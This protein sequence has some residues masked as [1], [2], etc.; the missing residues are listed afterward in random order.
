M[1]K[2]VLAL[3]LAAMI[4]AICFAGVA[5]AADPPA[6]PTASAEVQKAQAAAADTVRVL[7]TAAIADPAAL[8]PTA[9]AAPGRG[10]G[11]RIAAHTD[12]GSGLGLKAPSRPD[13]WRT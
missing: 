1:R 13:R 7:D 9:S 5:S 4:G 2:N 11:L 10:L 3:C 12:F 8:V 6:V